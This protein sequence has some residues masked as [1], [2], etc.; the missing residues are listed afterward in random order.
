MLDVRT[1]LWAAAIAVPCSAWAQVAP[2][3]T[4]ADRPVPA[5]RS[6]AKTA[7]PRAEEPAPGV[8]STDAE[9][10]LLLTLHRSHQGGIIASDFTKTRTDSPELKRYGERLAQEHRRLDEAVLALAKRRGVA[11]SE[12]AP[13]AQEVARSKRERT[14][15]NR[16]TT[17]RGKEFDRAFLAAMMSNQREAIERAE[18]ARSELSDPQLRAQLDKLLHTF[19]EQLSAAQGLAQERRTN[20]PR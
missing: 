12:L 9:Q 2:K 19:A 18:R 10:Q 8:M 5:E 7:L 11:L 1:W 4:A 6:A 3:K 14:M 17:L 20:P 16:L 13:D 15:M